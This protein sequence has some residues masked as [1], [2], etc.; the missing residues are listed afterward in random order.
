MGNLQ[1]RGHE[2]GQEHGEQGDQGE[3]LEEIVSRLKA[4]PKAPTQYA[5][6]FLNDDYTTMEFVIEM[7]QRFFRK[8]LL[9][10]EEIMLRVHNQGRSLVGVYL[11]EIAETKVHQVHEVAAVRGFPM[12]C[13]MEPHKP[14]TA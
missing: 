10:A 7:L 9:E 8:T 4:R 11:H 6:F 5:V 3:P 12:K 2:G 1:G 14:S 13:V